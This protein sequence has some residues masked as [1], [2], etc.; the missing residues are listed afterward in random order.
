MFTRGYGDFN[1]V[2]PSSDLLA[3]SNLHPAKYGTFKLVQPSPSNETAS[4]GNSRPSSYMWS[5]LKVVMFST[6]KGGY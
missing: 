6:P 5:G 2:Q 4:F 1:G 3:S